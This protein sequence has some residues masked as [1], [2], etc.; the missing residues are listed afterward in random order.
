MRIP[1][2]ATRL[3]Q[4]LHLLITILKPLLCRLRV[5]GREYVP[6]TGGCI[7]AC[8]HTRG[9]DYVILGYAAPRQ[10]Y[11]MAKAELFQVNRWLTKFLWGV[12]T[13]PVQRGRSDLGAIQAAE[14]LINDGHAVG[15]FP[16]GTRSP[17]GRL[18]KG[19][20]GAARIATQAAVIVVPAAVINAG[21]LF[22]QLGRRPEIIVRFGPS[23]RLDEDKTAKENTDRIMLAIAQLLPVEK[24]GYYGAVAS[25]VTDQNAHV[26][27]APTATDIVDRRQD[28]PA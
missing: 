24:R 16:E 6:E 10:I 4:G 19:K 28:F 1:R 14:R 20:T 12:G 13:F 26:E 3:W 17:D 2:N 22:S 11:Y 23:L 9:P 5:E 7:V 15:M 8:T 18:T 27:V 25:T 21:A